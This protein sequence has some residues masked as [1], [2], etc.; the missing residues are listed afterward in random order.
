MNN[1]ESNVPY[2]NPNT[3][4]APRKTIS[5]SIAD[6]PERFNSLHWIFAPLASTK[7]NYPEYLVTLTG[8]VRF[9]D[10]IEASPFTGWW[11]RDL[12]VEAPFQLKEFNETIEGKPYRAFI[13]Q[14]WTILVSVGGIGMSTAANS[15]WYVNGFGLDKD[16]LVQALQ[17]NHGMSDT[18]KFW[19]TTRV[20]DKS[21]MYSV[22]YQ[23]NLKGY[24]I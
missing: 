12:M 5:I 17:K 15:E 2:L 19:V 11:S 22:C 20:S 10:D 14:Q 8:A 1:N 9:D 23:I 16:F 7:P 3:A 24:L 13:L 4:T 18:V 6:Q 21:I